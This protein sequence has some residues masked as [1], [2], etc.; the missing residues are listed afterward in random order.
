VV[1]Q[2]GDRPDV[3]MRTYVKPTI[4]AQADAAL[5]MSGILPSPTAVKPLYTEKGP[6]SDL[7]S[8]DTVT[9]SKTGPAGLDCEAE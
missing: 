5:L 7:V 2:F 1:S 9:V 4:T 3:I 8:A 6:E